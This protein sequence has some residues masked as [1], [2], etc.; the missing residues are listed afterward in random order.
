[1]GKL[2]ACFV[3][4]IL[5]FAGAGCDGDNAAADAAIKLIDAAP[6]AKEFLDAPPP[7]YDFTCMGN[8]APTTAAGQITLSGTVRQVNFTG[9]ISV[10]PLDG[11]AVRS[12]TAGAA[13][14]T[15]GNTQGN[16]TSDA[17]GDWSI[18]PIST[19][20]NPLDVYLEASKTGSRTLYLYPASPFI[21]DQGMIP[22][23]TFA[24]SVISGLAII[25]GGCTQSASNGMIAVAVTDCGVQPITENLVISIKQGGN[26]VT[27]TTVID[28][29]SLSAMAA[30][31]F[32]VCNVPPNPTTTVGATYNATTAMRAHDV[33]VV[34][35]TTTATLL[36]PGY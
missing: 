21:A 16:D 24:P 25:P 22:M 19:S 31:V 20:M 18:G 35:D 13:N 11:A 3:V 10:D 23:L 17:M 33:K 27:G 32:L 6:D 5:A 30:G 15:G 7:M 9:S 12:C 34:A 1:M 36:R 4:A 29:G 2:H 14:C 28:L 26:E 8:A